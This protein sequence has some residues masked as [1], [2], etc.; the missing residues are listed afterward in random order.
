MVKKIKKNRW[1]SIVLLLSLISNTFALENDQSNLTISRVRAVGDYAGDTY[2]GTIELWFSTS[3][4]WP[5]Q[6]PCTSTYNVTI[7]K[8]HQHLISA[9]Y[10]AFAAG[11]KVNI[12]VDTNLPIRGGSCEIS[13][14]DVIN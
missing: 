11:K 3:L 12:H 14:I 9:A 10:M 5:S 13:F 2:D 1:L 6:F 7:D 4:V 8:K